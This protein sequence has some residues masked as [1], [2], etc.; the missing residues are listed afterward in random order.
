VADAQVIRR[1]RTAALMHEEQMR[2]RGK[3][4]KRRKNMTIDAGDLLAAAAEH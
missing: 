4:A 3:A 2:K 1:M